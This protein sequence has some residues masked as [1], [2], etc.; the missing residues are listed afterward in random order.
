MGR[1]LIIDLI[2]SIDM[3]LFRYQSNCNFFE[4]SLSFFSAF[5]INFLVFL[6]II[7]LCIIIVLTCNFPETHGSL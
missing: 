2:S 1:F 3:L 7:Y 5:R 4:G 6:T